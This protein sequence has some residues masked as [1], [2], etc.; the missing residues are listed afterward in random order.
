MVKVMAGIVLYNAEIERLLVEIKS[1]LPQVDQICLCDNGSAN[2]KLIEKK[3]KISDRIVFLKNE[4][5]LGIG[6]AS[7][8]ICAYAEKNGFEWVLML[9]HDTVC[10]FNLVDTYKKFT[11]DAALGMMCPNVVDRELVRNIYISTG[12]EE[13]EYIERCIQS[14]T[15][16]R[17]A[18]W[19]K[20]GGFNEWMFIDF[21]DFDIC[22]K[23][24]INGYRILRCKTVTV[25]HQLGK[26][27]FSK[28]SSKYEKISKLTGIE[29]IRYLSYKNE[30]SKDRIYYCTRNNIA[31]IRLYSSY[32]DKF[33]EWKDFYYRILKRI[34]RSNHRLMIIS[35]TIRGMHDGFRVNIKPYKKN[36]NI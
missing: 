27:T 17:I 35:Q 15:F 11:E 18:A 26:R 12:T 23:M 30:F 8:Q 16:V 21:V 29:T 5:N 34:I 1:I 4:E 24:E 36:C 13:I 10:P 19:K 6:V 28:F 31:Y 9:D 32:I 14:A 20:C 25:D 3:I 7:N 22:K 2:I 33:K